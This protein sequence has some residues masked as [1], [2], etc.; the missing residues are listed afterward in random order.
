MSSASGR[1]PAPSDADHVWVLTVEYAATLRWASD[2]VQIAGL[3][4]SAQAVEPGLDAGAVRNAIDTAGGN[5]SQDAA[6]FEVYLPAGFD[7]AR[8]EAD[9]ASLSGAACELARLPTTWGASGRTGV[10]GSR[11]VVL[12]G[13]V[14]GP[15]YGD[16]DEPVSFQV[17][18][19]DIDDRAIIPAPTYR[20]DADTWPT[21][22]DD[23][24]GRS[25]G[26]VFGQP[27]VIGDGYVPAT[28]AIRVEGSQGRAANGAIACT[29]GS[30]SDGDTVTVNGTTYTARTS[31]SLSTEFAIGASSLDLAAALAGVVDTDGDVNATQAATT[32]ALEAAAAGSD[33]NGI[34]LAT[35][36]ASAFA[37][38]GDTLANGSD[39]YFTDTLQV[40][41]GH[42]GAT[43]CQVYYLANSDTGRWASFTIAIVAAADGLGQ[44]VST[45]DVSS[46]SQAIRTC[47]EFWVDWRNGPGISTE[48]GQALGELGGIT[49][50]M[51]R[52][53]SVPVDWSRQAAGLGALRGLAVGGYFDEP[54]TPMDWVTDRVLGT[55]PV[56]RDDAPVGVALVRVPYDAPASAAV[57]HLEE[58]RRVTRTGPIIVT[59]DGRRA[60]VRVRWGLDGIRGTYRRVTVLSRSTSGYVSDV[61]EEPVG[62]AVVGSRRSIQ[63]DLPDCWSEA[64]AYAAGRW[65]LWTDGTP[66]R[67]VD[68]DVDVE[69]YGWLA[70]GDIVT[71]TA[72]D[73]SL[74]RA[75]CMVLDIERN[76]QPRVPVV[77]Q[78]L[79]ARNQVVDNVETAV[80]GDAAEVT[81]FVVVGGSSSLSLALRSE[82]GGATWSTAASPITGSFDDSRAVLWLADQ[83]LYVV[84]GEI[85]AFATSPDGTTWTKRG[86]GSQDVNGLAYDT[87]SQTM[88][89]VAENGHIYTSVG[90]PTD[91]GSWSSTTV[92]SAAWQDVAWSGAVFVAVGNSGAVATSPDGIT[93][94][95]RTWVAG[96]DVL[97][98]CWSA[99]LSTFVAV[100]KGGRV[101]T[102]PGG[103]T[104]TSQTSGTT[105]DLYAVDAGGGEVVC[106]GGTFAT[107]GV[108][109]ASSNATAWAS[110][111][112]VGAKRPQAVRYSAALGRWVIVGNDGLIATSPSPVGTWT[113]RT[114][115]TSEILF[116]ASPPQ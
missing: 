95:T 57:A 65:R 1:A 58:G 70:P 24:V 45:C 103:V 77:L 12:R 104:W 38:S 85:G 78:V 17:Q 86:I 19:Y 63:V 91:L 56:S 72:S 28:P 83:R 30:V 110:A 60:E 21:A 115:G 10:W 7:L 11:H 50:W 54:M 55:F 89:A 44:P 14:V 106:A 68:V 9:G 23:E 48:D 13:A 35:S 3:P 46:K 15:S 73:V 40:S 29:H 93:W 34:D 102:S 105:E 62:E 80:A 18:P 107:T 61:I 66:H 88:V 5:S 32:V 53:S 20:V 6:T 51:L 100:G 116:D 26:M 101:T 25:Y 81:D 76:D 22:P 8:F 109:R 96:T 49:S 99:T 94:T 79:R 37:L 114:S 82:D 52:R 71:Y 97:A 16:V 92:G 98:V 90:D 4:E 69:A 42:V 67:T 27:G 64:T 39:E 75:T 47:S 2:D 36:N 43:S 113:V 31:P 59:R 33:G 112:A 84:G 87:A 41:W 74:L 111:G 108:V